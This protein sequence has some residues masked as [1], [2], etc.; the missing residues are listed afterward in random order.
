M[1]RYAVRVPFSN[2]GL[3]DLVDRLAAAR[4]AIDHM[5]G[6][7]AAGVRAVEPRPDERYYMC[8]LADGGLTC[9][10]DALGPV[11]RGDSVRAVLRA[12]LLSEHAEESV[13]AAALDVLRN[14]AASLAA[15]SDDAPLQVAC[16]RLADAAGDLADWRRDPAR[17]VATVADLDGAVRRH[18]AVRSAHVGFLAAT[19]PLVPI[20]DTLPSDLIESLQSLEQASSQAGVGGALTP[21]LAAA[22]EGIDQ[23]LA[24]LEVRYQ[25]LSTQ[26]TP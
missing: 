9:L 13:D 8:V 12:A 25:D 11:P 6:Q 1:S 5:T 14:A 23:S 16:R 21:V 22:L 19:D 17:E 7:P 3:D 26:G 15:R 24:E 10:D 4:D 2:P 18:D 20:Q